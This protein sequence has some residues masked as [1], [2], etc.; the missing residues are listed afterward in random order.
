VGFTVRVIAVPLPPAEIGLEE[1]QVTVPDELP[2]LHPVPLA[3]TKVRL[4]GS[5]SVTVIVPLDA[6][7]PPLDTVMV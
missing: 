7:V 1:V 6:A 5:T 3:D 2:Q 4:T